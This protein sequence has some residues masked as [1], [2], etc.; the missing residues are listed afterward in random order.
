MFNGPQNVPSRHMSHCCLH[1]ISNLL[2]LTNEWR[3]LSGYGSRLAA[4]LA[5]VGF[6][7]RRGVLIMSKFL[8]FVTVFVFFPMRLFNRWYPLA[9]RKIP[10][11][12]TARPWRPAY[13]SLSSLA[14]A[15]PSCKAPPLLNY[16]G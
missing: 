11:T 4:L 14:E 7:D 12:M 13:H 15:T 5:V 16:S 9:S 8:I 10:P 3:W 1:V 2:A 6:F